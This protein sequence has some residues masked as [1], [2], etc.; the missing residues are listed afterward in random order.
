MAD[1]LAGHTLYPGINWIEVASGEPFEASN[2]MVPVSKIERAR[3]NKIEKKLY[4]SYRVRPDMNV[5]CCWFQFKRWLFFRS[6]LKITKIEILANTV[7]SVLLYHL[8]LLPLSVIASSVCYL[9]LER[10]W[11][12]DPVVRWKKFSVFFLP[13]I[14]KIQN[15]IHYFFTFSALQL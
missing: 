10:T 8:S 4:W 15:V 12:R 3:E 9:D 5:P 7:G 13:K 1:L 2:F 14:V 11:R 6:R